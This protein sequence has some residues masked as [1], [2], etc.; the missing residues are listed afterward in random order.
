MSLDV[1]VGSGLAA[2]PDGEGFL[3]RPV[4]AGVVGYEAIDDPRYSLWHFAQ[5]NEALDVDAHNT[6]LLEE[7]AR[8]AHG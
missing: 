5:M 2:Y 6:I 3:L 8:K 1:Q 7:E 4:L